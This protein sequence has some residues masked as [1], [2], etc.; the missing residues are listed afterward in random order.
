MSISFGSS[1]KSIGE[2]AFRYCFSLTNLVLPEPI[3]TIDYATFLTLNKI[4]SKKLPNTLNSI[5]R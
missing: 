3:E 4:K 1:V 2:E 5:D